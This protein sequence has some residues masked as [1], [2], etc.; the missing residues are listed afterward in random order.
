MPTAETKS[1]IEIHFDPRVN[2]CSKHTIKLNFFQIKTSPG[3]CFNIELGLAFR[4]ASA[5]LS[6]LQAAFLRTPVIL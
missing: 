6:L 2:I 5:C 4:Q 3:A 1:N